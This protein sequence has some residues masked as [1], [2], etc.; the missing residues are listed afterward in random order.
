MITINARLSQDERDK[1]MFETNA[2]QRTAKKVTRESL[3]SF[4]S[5]NW[6]RQCLKTKR[7]TLKQKRSELLIFA[8]EAANLVSLGQILQLSLK[9]IRAYS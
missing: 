5:V 3:E 6:K 8:S 7:I 1:Q 9:K 2:A 4:F